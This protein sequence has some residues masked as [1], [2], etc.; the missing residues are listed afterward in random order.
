MLL[1]ADPLAEI[2]ANIIA[3]PGLQPQERIADTPAAL[4]APELLGQYNPAEHLPDLFADLT[5]PD[6]SA[7]A[8]REVVTFTWVKGASGD[9]TDPANWD[10]GAV[11]LPGS[12]VFIPA[13][14]GDVAITYSGGNLALAGVISSERVI[15]SSGVITLSGESSFR[16]LM[17][18]NG[19][20]IV[21]DSGATFTN[22]GIVELRDNAVFTNRGA[23]HNGV[24]GLLLVDNAAEFRQT[25][26]TLI[27][28][29]LSVIAVRS[30][31]VM[32]VSGGT[33][34][35]HD[36]DFLVSGL[37]KLH[38]S[39]GSL[40]IDAG[41]F[42]F[43]GLAKFDRSGGLLLLDKTELR[44]QQQSELRNSGGELRLQ[45]G[46]IASA[47]TVKLTGGSL[48]GSGT[49][50]ANLTS[51][52]ILSPGTDT[53]RIGKLTINGTYVQ[54]ENAVIRID[55][56][57]QASM[58][59]VEVNGS[60]VL[61]VG[62]I[63]VSTT[64][65]FVGV[66][67]EKF[68]VLRYTGT[69]FGEFAAAMLPEGEFG[70]HL[71]WS[72]GR[73][74][75]VTKLNEIDV[76]EIIRRD[77]RQIFEILRQFGAF[78]NLD[79][80]DYEE[81]EN[82]PPDVPIVPGSLDDLFAIT[83]ELQSIATPSLNPAATREELVS[84]LMVAGFTVEAIQG[85]L[86]MGGDIYPDTGDDTL[87]RF[88]L[89]ATLF[90][91]KS[92]DVE[93]TGDSF[94]DATSGIL[95]GL[96]A[97]IDIDGDID[98]AGTLAV[99]VVLGVDAT[100][101]FLLSDTRL[102]LG[103]EG[104]G[105]LTGS[106]DVVGLSAVSV[107]GAADAD[108]NVSLA[109]NDGQASYRYDELNNDLAS[110]LVPWVDG[111]AEVSLEVAVAAASLTF[112]ADYTIATT[113]QETQTS[114]TPSLDGYLHLPE[115]RAA[116]S[117]QPAPV[118]LAGLFDSAGSA[119]S[120]SGA[121][122]DGAELFGMPVSDVQAT[123]SVAAGAMAGSGSLKLGVDFLQ[124][125]GDSVILDLAF[126]FDHETVELDALLALP[127]ATVLDRNGGTLLT[128][129][130]IVLD[131][132]LT[133]IFAAGA[134]SG[135]L[136]LSAGSAALIPADGYTIS[137]TDGAD[138]TNTTALELSFDFD[139]QAFWI[140][141][142]Q[143]AVILPGVIRVRG[144]GISVSYDRSNTAPDQ[145]LAE[146]DH[147]TAE[148]LILTDGA[149]GSVPSLLIDDFV[150]RLDGFDF[151]N[152]A[153]VLPTVSIG[154]VLE[155]TRPQFG[156]EDV[157]VT[158]NNVSVGAFSFAA[159]GVSLFTESSGVLLLSD[160]DDDADSFAI[161]GVFDIA[162]S[163][164]SLSID[165]LELSLPDVLYTAVD[166][167]LLTYDPFSTA[168]DPILF[169]VDNV[170]VEILIFGPPYLPRIAASE[171]VIRRRSLEIG[172][173]SVAFLGEVPV[174]EILLLTE[175]T[176][177]LTGVT[178]SAADGLDIDAIGIDAD[179]VSLFGGEIGLVSTVTD[180][181]DDGNRAVTGVFE[182]ETRAFAL[183]LDHFE[184]SIPEALELTADGVAFSYDPSNSS[185]D[186]QLLHLDAID[187]ELVLFAD[188]ISPRIT[189]SNLTIRRDGFSLGAAAVALTGTYSIIDELLEVTTPT[190]TLNDIEYTRG[191]GLLS[192]TIGIGAAN[193][194]AFPGDP[195]IVVAFRVGDDDDDGFAIFG[196]YNLITAAFAFVVDEFELS[197]PD[198]LSAAASNV[199]LTYDPSSTAPDQQLV[200]ID[201]L[202][203]DVLL[204]GETNRPQVEVS[205]LVIRRNGFSLGAGTV[206]LT[207]TIL[208]ADVLEVE[209]PTLLFENIVYSTEDGISGA[210]GIAAEAATLF[211]ER[212]DFEAKATD[213]GDNDGG[214]D[215]DDEDDYAVVG[216]FNLETYAFSL[217]I[218]EFELSIPEVLSANGEN[219]AF[220]YDPSDDSADQELMRLGEL[221]AELLFFDEANR[222]EIEIS[223]LVIRKNGFSLG[224][225]TVVIDSTVE[226]AGV[227][228]IDDPILTLQDIVYSTDAG[229]SGS[230]E[231]TAEEVAL[232]PDRED[233]EAKATDDGDKDGVDDADDDDDY[234]VVGR[235]DLGTL[236]F[237]L[238]I[239]ELELTIP[240]V[241]SAKGENL[242]FMYDPG[243]DSTDQVLMRLE[244]LEAD[245]LL[246]D[247]ADP[248]QI[249]VSDLAIHKNGFS[250]GEGRVTIETTVVIADVLSID[251]PALSFR[252]IVY[253]TDDGISGTIAVSANGVSLFP[254][255]EAFTLLVAD[256]D[257][258]DELALLGE[259][260]IHTQRFSLALD[261]ISLIIPEVLEGQAEAV[262]FTFDPHDDSADQELL[263]VA[264]IRAELL[265]F[266]G[267]NI[268]VIEISDLSVRRNSFSMESASLTIAGVVSIGG[269]LG[270]DSP[271][272]TLL[273]VNYSTDSG[274][275]DLLGGV[276]VSA[277]AASLFPGQ[278]AVS[279][280]ITDGTGA[281]DADEL[282]IL[283]Q[284]SFATG[285]FSLTADQMLLTVSTA[286]RMEASHLTIAYDPGI[287]EA[288]TIF[289]LER[290]VAS[291]PQFSGLGTVE[292]EGVAV[293][294]DG[295]TLDGIAWNQEEGQVI[296][297]GGFIEFSGLR[298]GV[299]EFAMSYGDETTFSGT[300]VVGAASAALFPENTTFEA[301]A[302][303]IAG[304]FDFSNSEAPG[305]FTLVAGTFI[306]AFSDLIRI[307]ATDF[308]FTP[309]GEIIAQAEVLTAA[310]PILAVSG[311]IHDLSISRGGAFE[312][313]RISIAIGDESP[314]FALAS[315]LPVMVTQID[316]TFLGDLD[317]DGTQDEDEFFDIMN[318]ELGV[319]GRFDF[320]KFDALPFT[321]I[322]R[323]G[324]Q[325]DR[326]EITDESSTFSFSIRWV[327]NELKPWNIG[328]IE[329]GFADLGIGETITLGGTIVLGGYVEGVWQNQY[330]GSF[331]LQ[332]SGLISG[333]ST[334]VSGEILG[335]FDESTGRMEADGTLTVG[336]TMQD[337]IEVVNATLSFS[338]VVAVSQ[339]PFDLQL[340]SLEFHSVTVERVTVYI[341]DILTL[342]TTE[343]TLNFDPGPDE[344]IATFGTMTADLQALGISGTALN[345]A[346]GQ[347]GRP[348]ALENFG[349]ALTFT[350]D[351]ATK[352][353]WPDWLPISIDLLLLQWEDFNNDIEDFT[354]RLSATIDVSGLG[355]SQLR[356]SG[357]VQDAVIDVSLLLAGEFPIV[358]I[359][360]FGVEVGGEMFGAKVAGSFFFAIAKV[361]A[362]GNS[363]PDSDFTTEVANRYLYG[364]I[365]GSIDVVGYA[366]FE[367]RLGIS[368]FG[369]LQGYVEIITPMVIEPFSGLTINSLRAGI[370]FNS[371]LPDV[372]DPRELGTNPGF[373][374]AAELSL[375]E[376][377]EM[378]LASVVR[379]GQNA[380]EGG[381]WTA[382]LDHVR[383]EGG[384]SLISAYAS[385]STLEFEGDFILSTDGKLL[386]KGTLKLGGTFSLDGSLFF[387]LSKI[388]SGDVQILYLAELPADTTIFRLYGALRLDFGLEFSGPTLEAGQII[389][390]PL[391][392]E[393]ADQLRIVV[394]GTQE[395]TAFDFVTLGIRGTHIL[396]VSLGQTRLEYTV[397]GELFL[398]FVGSLIG[399]GGKIVLQFNDESPTP[400]IP[401]IWG[402][403]ALQP[404]D[405][406]LLRSL[407][408]NYDALAILRFNTTDRD[409][410]ETVTIP[411]Q[412]E[413]T[414]FLIEAQAVSLLL[415]GFVVFTLNDTEWFRMTGAA[416]MSWSAHGIDALI[417]A[418]LVIGD[419][420]DPFIEFHA[421]GYMRI[422]TAGIAANIDVSLDDAS[423]LE[424]IG[425]TIESAAFHLILNTTL[426]EITYDIPTEFPAVQGER[427]VT[428]PRGP[429]DATGA[430]IGEPAPYLI[431]AA[432]G[433]VT[434]LDSFS[435][436][437]RFDL[438]VTPDLAELRFDTILALRAGD[439]VILEFVTR[440]GIRLNAAGIVG[441]L[442]LSFT[443][444][445]AIPEILAFDFDATFQ[446]QFN[447]T[448]VAANVNGIALEAGRYARVRGLG[449][450]RVNESS[451][452]GRFDISLTPDRLSIFADGTLTLQA[453]GLTFLE[454][455]V[456]GEL[457]VGAT[458]IYGRIAANVGQYTAS[459]IE[460]DAAFSLEFNTT[461]QPVNGV[462]S[463]AG[464]R[465]S[466][467]GTI[468][469][470]G[471]SFDGFFIFT[472]DVNVLTMDAEFDV[473]LNYED[474]TLFSFHV[475]HEFVLELPGIAEEIAFVLPGEANFA[476]AF[477]FDLDASFALQINT[478][479]QAKGNL[480]K[481]PYA[482]ILA[483][484]SLTIGGLSLAGNFYFSQNIRAIQATA[485]F[486]LSITAGSTSIFE[487]AGAGAFTFGFSGIA[488]QLELAMTGG[489]ALSGD[490]GFDFSAETSFALRFNTSGSDVVVGEH[491]IPGGANGAY[492]KVV[493]TGALDVF[494]SSL[495]G[496]FTITVDGTGLFMTAVA[497]VE[498]SIDDTVILGLAVD[499]AFELDG[500]GI[501][502]VVTATA[503]TNL[504]A[505]FG[506]DFDA[507]ALYRIE[508]NSSKG[509]KM[510]AGVTLEAGPYFRVTILGHAVI[511]GL[512]LDIALTLKQGA[513]E[514]LAIVD[515]ALAIVTDGSE[516]F[517][518]DLA[519]A[520]RIT[521]GGLAM[522]G[523]LDL[524]GGA[525]QEM[526]VELDV[527]F[528]LEIN[529]T[530][531]EQRFDDVVL[532][533]SAYVRV[534]GEGS[535]T[536]VGIEVD[537]RFEIVVG[538]DGTVRLDA[539]GSTALNV[540]GS[541]LLAFDVA[542]GL[543]LEADGMAG[544]IAIAPS[545]NG[546]ESLGL[547][548]NAEASFRFEVNTTPRSQILGAQTLEAGPFGR[549]VVA[550]AIGVDSVAFDGEL[551]LEVN[552]SGIR[553]SLKAFFGLEVDG[554]QLIGFNAV[555]ALAIDEAGI[556]AI[557]DLTVAARG[558][559]NL[560]FSLSGNFQLFLNT[561]GEDRVLGTHLL[562]GSEVIRVRGAGDLSVSGITLTGEFEMSVGETQ[563]E[564]LADARLELFAGSTR[565]LGFGVAGG[566]RIDRFGLVAVI[567]LS[568]TND[569]PSGLGFEFADVA[570]QLQLN[571]TGQTQEVGLTT[572]DGSVQ[573]A[574]HATGAIGIAGLSLA[575]S[576]SIVKSSAA[577]LT[578]TATASFTLAG[579]DVAVSGAFG[580]YADGL[581]L[582]LELTVGKI[583][584]P[585]AS[586]E[587]SFRLEINTRDVATLSI[588]AN[589][590]QV[591]ISNLK[592]KVLG[593]TATGT[594]ILT[595]L[596]A[597]DF[598]IDIPS[599]SKLSVSIY[600]LVT[601][602][603]SGFV[604]SGGSFDLTGSAS[605]DV[606]S[607]GYV[608]LDGEMSVRIR[609]AGL[610]AN[611][612]GDIY[613]VN[614]KVASI[615]KS[616]TFGSPS[617]TF[618]QDL[619]FSLFLVDVDA[620]FFF[621][622]DTSGVYASFS[623]GLKLWGKTV[624]E[625][626]GYFKAKGSSLEYEVHGTVN[627]SASVGPLKASIK[628]TIAIWKW[629]SEKTI[630]TPF[631]SIT[632]PASGAN[633]ILSGSVSV[634]FS[635]TVSG[636]TYS[637]RF[638]V[639]VGGKVTSSGTFSV[640]V[641]GTIVG[642]EVSETVKVSLK[643]GISLSASNVVGA[644]AFLD[645]NRNRILDAG[646]PWTIVDEDGLF[647]FN[648]EFG[649]P[650]VDEPEPTPFELLDKNGNDRLDFDEA[651]LVLFGGT[652][653]ETGQFNTRFMT[654]PNNELAGLSGM[655]NAILFVDAN[656]NG[657]PDGE[658]ISV[659]TG[660]DG[661]YSLQA[662]LSPGG[663]ASGDEALGALVVYDLN[664]NSGLESNEGQ[665]VLVGGESIET[666][667]ANTAPI[668]L[669]TH[670]PFALT[671]FRGATV[672][673][674][675]NLNSIRDPGEPSVQTD[676][677]GAYNFLTAVEI[678]NSS[679]LG[680]LA[681]YD[682]DGDGVLDPEEGTM[683]IIGGVAADDETDPNDAAAIA[684]LPAAAPPFV[685]A[686][687]VFFDVNG[688]MTLD[689][690]EKSVPVVDDYYS[691]LL[692]P[693]NSLGRL[694]PFDTNGNGQIDLE[695]GVIVI[696]GGTDI[697]NGLPNPLVIQM[698]ASDYGNGFQQT[699]SPLTTVLVAMVDA[700]DDPDTAVERMNAAFGLP[701]DFDIRT[702][703]PGSDEADGDG[704]ESQVLALQ[705]QLNVLVNNASAVLDDG[706]M[707][708]IDLQ[709]AVVAQ[710]AQRVIEVPPLA[711]EDPGPAQISLVDTA[712]IT[713][714][715][716]GAA[717]A[718]GVALDAAVLDAATQVIGATNDFIAELAEDGA[719]GL[720][721][722]LAAVKAVAAT[723]SAVALEDIVAGTVD[724]ASVITA[725][726]GDSLVSRVENVELAANDPPNAPIVHDG[727]RLSIPVDRGSVFTFDVTDPDNRSRDLM[728]SAV[729]DNL[730]LI[731]NEAIVFSGSG[732]ERVL[733]VQPV[734]GGVGVANITI[735]VSDGEQTAS[736]VVTVSVG[737]LGIT[738]WAS[739]A[740]DGIDRVGA[741][742]EI[743]DDSSFSEPRR[744]GIKALIV[745]FSEPMDRTT[746][747]A[748][749]VAI[750]GRRVDGTAIDLTG[751]EIHT[752][753]D[754]D[755]TTVTISFSQALPDQAR[756]EVAL[757]GMVSAGGIS[758]SGDVDRVITALLG[759]VN[760]DRVVDEHDAAALV[761]QRGPI[762]IDAPSAAAIRSDLNQDGRVTTLDLAGLYTLIG[763][764]AR[765][766]AGGAR[767]ASDVG[768]SQIVLA[769]QTTDGATTGHALAIGEYVH[770]TS[771]ER[772]PFMTLSWRADARSDHFAA[773]RPVVDDLFDNDDENEKIKKETW[774]LVS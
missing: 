280:A 642:V 412:T 334:E 294:T 674:D 613:I 542:G 549:V 12:L 257:D 591:R 750:H 97:N 716:A 636:T 540:D 358:G 648:E 505:E 637:K 310:I 748:D 619:E 200:Q 597:T 587:G 151:A 417:D 566:L 243:D 528:V 17:L 394:E 299:D 45:D 399:A 617:F 57:S 500:G 71:A 715:V 316:V 143:L 611:F 67:D 592:L 197:V 31:A 320:S 743:P 126:A 114:F 22:M 382:L 195:D 312:A 605:F 267:D 547:S 302:T 389:D 202:A 571:T 14:S 373:K 667:D 429:P 472:Q 449:A 15:V 557:L 188:S 733:T 217:T 481:G 643:N 419:E 265:L 251:Q 452:V 216:R 342:E 317:G 541:P 372:T 115:L 50:T 227:L 588:P 239:D 499:G 554:T 374:T 63:E 157:S 414:E 187:A 459:D 705:A 582:R 98:Y 226:L 595:G 513:G 131:A 305:N 79:A 335:T 23:F 279:F 669:D 639:S 568:L 271:S 339:D 523:S 84:G 693:A 434:I 616:I 219:L 337:V 413:P 77:I 142:D 34:V 539:N 92:D 222:P 548:V 295:F 391:E 512:Q 160:G 273:D 147:L 51:G 435:M 601:V 444:G 359:G 683:V 38:Q 150:L 469:V 363:I 723:Q 666:G 201:R 96:G 191:N 369:P 48:T 772:R 600:G 94:S 426:E 39:G 262:L 116:D 215:D 691:F 703:D 86:T 123:V 167:A 759:D 468:V 659:I 632:V 751:I 483:A 520:V 614:L 213:D 75:L 415:E 272:V 241:L 537:G 422:S 242:A 392:F 133:G 573:A 626:S 770:V 455:D 771:Y 438:L 340:E 101:L 572:V 352:V 206:A 482:R 441:A 13:L 53:D 199:I 326:E 570:F 408:L 502:G 203:V 244:S 293:R 707:S 220:M 516:V 125:S 446:L 640:T 65:G 608:K 580:I 456:A 353:K 145:V 461:D 731:P 442:D 306:F 283:G 331:A 561:T 765:H 27:N 644:T 625:A 538:G 462:P 678:D 504:L 518:F 494:G 173:G 180:G 663:I 410:T 471:I 83:G 46:R 652:N 87:I 61:L 52:G 563:L 42:V 641:G 671:A 393:L 376:W 246:F 381:F 728:V 653:L 344:D 480:E 311:T 745:Q 679:I 769:N 88:R 73:L 713:S 424:Q 603:V 328:P 621:S 553:A 578:V 309:E 297:L 163:Q 484:G 501:A 37:A 436:A 225:G 179:S 149:T 303:A 710:L 120:L 223:D 457:S 690:D 378:L 524:R 550:G 773:L 609:N 349:V 210:I 35:Q 491:T 530:G 192:G 670:N 763:H 6:D 266:G 555:G 721:R 164:Y 193:V 682:I 55:V 402:A 268:P 209:T 32:T 377:R 575:G 433:A 454:L 9:W 245:L 465:V 510:L 323:I 205:D 697:D 519:V 405:F 672:F 380:S 122:A 43:S 724:A 730:L 709:S 390:A 2:A 638:S 231:I 224:E 355:G 285:A 292:V 440:G 345:F 439:T 76:S 401:E 552:G 162:D 495:V 425:I 474:T 36:A 423:L 304:S 646:E 168:D 673:F 492:M 330:G 29:N 681:I 689:P 184:L 574:V 252:N 533:P 11:P 447:S 696:F 318:F 260:T 567:D 630:S 130:E 370:T 371:T 25:A 740:G 1:S 296:N 333:V 453:G 82:L 623:G 93:F 544:I 78:F 204:F 647:S 117:G 137:V 183:F 56:L 699:A 103:V 47:I 74:E 445:F 431:V 695:E 182:T 155:L 729:S 290:A 676:G 170:E 735:V 261:R 212:A 105:T 161:E 668:V 186:Q 240:E 354:M 256:G 662:V 397:E 650:A 658:E 558:G 535:L 490:L 26:G 351:T 315:F 478:T 341:G 16:N 189:A 711:E 635:V 450:L 221:E 4:S 760:S 177:T 766:I 404:A 348:K 463:N 277:Q 485:D 141:V 521:T 581:A 764:D 634:G 649:E 526:G 338:F 19:A 702:F 565:I 62:S 336:F 81:Q 618:S 18:K 594:V 752:N 276:A 742:L 138:E 738:G 325:E 375:P 448:G 104:S 496:G 527:E 529:T 722:E 749:K 586:L 68:A 694:A 58:D 737:V 432:Q 127:E 275:G 747:T 169:Q 768:R 384:L 464:L 531:Q 677:N 628:V 278:S 706:S 507:D 248:P 736:T 185:P 486:T 66:I 388:F 437:G 109:L 596:S 80:I 8:A 762:A 286:I 208:V 620:T 409:M 118:S 146:I 230:I 602:S 718:E 418:D 176:L 218:D 477:G 128:A 470:A 712:T 488:G 284:Y 132:E 308:Q 686:E 720:D 522:Y 3:C 645:L 473:N 753:L 684:N 89:L 249:T 536:V 362:D 59:S 288:Q 135:S 398:D 139:T 383:I 744:G 44:L 758:L 329:L 543:A 234:A 727:S 767:A 493:A 110:I 406:D 460:F 685:G 700:G 238:M 585:G 20:E 661:S 194:V 106:A 680:P 254:D 343:A 356:L 598:R 236:A 615:D 420:N 298:V 69:R 134:I 583:S 253:S 430:V 158:R 270:I 60:V 487:F 307:E 368:Q 28:D 407:G 153:I 233:F 111:T 562:N 171:L 579:I 347:D 129:S 91:D 403:L 508:L 136:E 458:G 301:Q 754:R 289:T 756:Y 367:L 395:V 757:S 350:P 503:T 360:G 387:D 99:D 148:L 172:Q 396:D 156:F 675:G 726:S 107:A 629:P 274:S 357:F 560:G 590:V 725:Y 144:Q 466:A 545:T 291:S 774:G 385:S 232:F 332:E 64:N 379:Q 7:P 174:G 532:D 475:D 282:A 361:D 692:P 479:N 559:A 152:A 515:G 259:F 607:K 511:S 534:A 660:S 237:L 610:S 255:V 196:S 247:E 701:A 30:S 688:N 70:F 314:L 556:A 599:T 24:E 235:F 476:R 551:R 313:S 427:T 300:V 704:V 41:V 604:T 113:N 119:W 664:G 546:L 451:L 655:A 622:V 633:F 421:L 755:A 154:D 443:D 198:V 589:T 140:S 159:V 514:L 366:G 654:L 717:V 214:D 564:V 181:T 10:R 708:S 525:I 108:I 467:D 576:F 175:P 741:E 746:V 346:I 229:I 631:G 489:G 739:V 207:D 698:L 651:R 321:P 569:L 178:Y 263:T 497:A 584:I 665:F 732:Q 624:A 498:F 386:L 411:G 509:E 593:L 190:V 428:L 49:I 21:N 327:N 211:P 85:G 719:A 365:L 761:A 90:S 112:A 95:A 657:L 656:L 319:S 687:L 714:I 734:A 72:A 577:S 258:D 517:S 506:L 5:E 54:T 102:T 166:D 627:Y 250:L 606:G 121:I 100:G 364:G 269:F 40:A 264:S 228:S 612:K 281:G 416:V 124:S 400:L 322:V 324:P 287:T 165:Q 33:V